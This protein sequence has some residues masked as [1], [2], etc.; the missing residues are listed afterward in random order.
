MAPREAEVERVASTSTVEV[1]IAIAW[2]MV[3][4]PLYC[5]ALREHWEDLSA[6]PEVVS[7]DITGAYTNAALHG[8]ETP[9]YMT[10]RGREVLAAILRLDG[11]SWDSDKLPVFRLRHALYGHPLAGDFWSAEFRMYAEASGYT[12]LEGESRS[13]KGKPQ[14]VLV[15]HRVARGAHGEGAAA[16]SAAAFGCLRVAG[17]ARSTRFLVSRHGPSGAVSDG[18]RPRCTGV[19][20]RSRRA[21]EKPWHG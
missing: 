1:R 9:Y 17:R 4:D 12:L 2:G 16:A 6:V 20:A 19:A 15:Y 14:L 18:P 3:F 13:S 5:P 7:F 11:W 10:L 8:R 21:P